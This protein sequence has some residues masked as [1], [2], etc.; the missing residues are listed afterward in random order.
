VKE[1]FISISLAIYGEMK[2]TSLPEWAREK[3]ITAHLGLSHMILFNLRKEGKIRSVSLRGEGKQYGARLY[4]V[5][6]IREHLA[7]QEKCELQQGSVR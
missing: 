7:K 3:Q 4:N 2:I 5:E 6:S 1:K